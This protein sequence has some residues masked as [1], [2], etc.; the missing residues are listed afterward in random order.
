MSY[1]TIKGNTTLSGSVPISGAKNSALP[2]MCAS[3]LTDKKLTL[4]NFPMLADTQK[5]ME[6]LSELGAHATIS[7]DETGS[8]GSPQILDIKVDN[9]L[10]I[11]AV[12][13]AVNQMRASVLVLGPLLA[14][15]GKAS[16]TLPG[17]DAIGARPIDLHL[18][19]LE[20]M[21]ASVEV[22]DGKVHTTAPKDGLKGAHIKFPIISVGATEHLMLSAALA[23]GDTVLENVALEPE[24][25]DLAL[26][27]QKM[28][29]PIEGIGT[30]ILQITGSNGAALQAADHHIIADRIEAASFAI[31]AIATKGDITLTHV[32]ADIIE[33][34]LKILEQGGANIKI[35]GN[36]IRVSGAPENFAPQI[37]DTAPYPGFATD[38]QAQL[39]ALLCL[40]NG[41]S[42]IN[43]LIFENRFMHAAEYQKMGAK[44]EI[45]GSKAMI[46]GGRPLFGATIAASDIRACFGLLIVAFAAEGETILRHIYH[47]DRGY[48]NFEQK[49]ANLGANMTRAEN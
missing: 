45:Q 5:L 19:G 38:I 46:H 49:F 4:R 39:M 32:N 3:L 22:S 1:L 7:K 29:V 44:I 2:L 8:T 13:E 27:L 9:I 47:L 41:R 43:E 34:F 36:H 26:L 30:S 20:A 48:E 17:G 23:K 40:V 16:V 25:T 15:E 42:E 28:G 18:K 35:D 12:H 6:I 24:I 31:A 21:G 11:L 33:N 10:S 37:I 14:R